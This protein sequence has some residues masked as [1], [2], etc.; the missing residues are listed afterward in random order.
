MIPTPQPKVVP[1]I[2]RLMAMAS[3]K[4]SHASRAR[5]SRQAGTHAL[6]HACACARMRACTCWGTP[7]RASAHARIDAQT[8]PRRSPRLPNAQQQCWY[9]NV[10]NT[11]SCMQRHACK[12]RNG[13]WHLVSKLSPMHPSQQL[14][15]WHFMTLQLAIKN[16]A[17]AEHENAGVSE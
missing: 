16:Y 4:W 7:S 8:F 1:C 2:S 11:S 15:R 9:T 13:C 17:Q 14:L 10:R 3:S 12:P 5:N 6:A